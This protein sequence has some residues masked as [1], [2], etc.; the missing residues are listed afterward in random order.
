[1]DAKKYNNG[2]VE[3]I[4]ENATET[5]LAIREWS[6]NYKPLETA[7]GSCIDNN[8]P[9]IAS[10]AGHSLMD[11]AYISMVV[12]KEN[13]GKII[14]I[15]NSVANI[16]NTEI[17]LSYM[18]SQGTILTVSSDMFHRKSMFNTIE[19]SATKAMEIGET[20]PNVQDLWNAHKELRLHDVGHS[21]EVANSRFSQR[22]ILRS[23][24]DELF[25]ILENSI[26]KKDDYTGCYYRTFVSKKGLKN[27]LQEMI[28]SV[29]DV[30]YRK[31]YDELT[32]T[33]R[34]RNNIRETIEK[35]HIE[36]VNFEEKNGQSHQKDIEIEK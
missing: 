16:R 3:S 10:C 14:N 34:Q 18:E 19:K 28:E 27:F 12:N 15:M 36:P 29:D 13:L 4:P 26:L 21:L 9:T 23:Y 32:D 11:S 6:E 20:L 22:L 5:A 17:C 25:P 33:K 8:I 24:S 7:I 2:K 31:Q 30:C 1:M 35:C